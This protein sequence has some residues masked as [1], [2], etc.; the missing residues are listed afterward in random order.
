MSVLKFY[1]TLG[2]QPARSVKTL[3]DLGK[4]KYELI[5]VNLR[6]N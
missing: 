5:E 4:I 2:S 1:W 3:L 6:N